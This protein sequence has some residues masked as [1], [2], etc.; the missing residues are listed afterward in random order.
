MQARIDHPRPVAQEVVLGRLGRGLFLDLDVTHQLGGSRQLGQVKG[1]PQDFGEDGGVF[2]LVVAAGAGELFGRTGLV[3][4]LDL[5]QLH[6]GLGRSILGRG[7]KELIRRIVGGGQKM[8]HRLGGGRLGDGDGRGR[9]GAGRQQGQ[10][11][12]LHVRSS[13]ARVRS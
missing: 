1:R 13:L 9:H 7:R 12:M 3:E 6:Q 4:A 5:G 10:G 2:G 11:E 8:R